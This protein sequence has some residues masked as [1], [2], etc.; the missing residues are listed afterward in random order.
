MSENKIA[1]RFCGSCEA[2]LPPRKT[3][4]PRRFCS[5]I[6]RKRAHRAEVSSRATPLPGAGQNAQII[7]MKSM[8]QKAKNEGV[9]LCILGPPL[10]WGRKDVDPKIIERIRTMEICRA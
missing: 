7:P 4:R 9:C 1:T 6:C 10:P 8:A 2:P 3:G 5:T